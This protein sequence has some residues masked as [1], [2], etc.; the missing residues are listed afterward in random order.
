VL[1]V[2]AKRLVDR[3]GEVLVREVA[4]ESMYLYEISTGDGDM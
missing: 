3:P 1:A 4:G 2:G